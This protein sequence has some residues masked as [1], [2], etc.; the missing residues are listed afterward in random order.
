VLLNLP[1][2]SLK[3]V[4]L[5]AQLAILDISFQ[6]AHALYAQLVAKHQTQQVAH[7]PQPA[8]EAAATMVIIGVVLHVLLALLVVSHVPQLIALHAAALDML[9]FQQALFPST[10]ALHAQE[11]A[12]TVI[13]Q[14]QPQ[15]ALFVPHAF[16]DLVS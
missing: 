11:T 1:V 16:L 14:V 13:L 3:P 6:Q 2:V 10:L 9:N 5:F 7:Q 12:Q 4:Q 15:L 8:Q